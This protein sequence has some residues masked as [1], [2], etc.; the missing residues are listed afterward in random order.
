MRRAPEAARDYPSPA[1][2]EGGERRDSGNGCE[3]W[4]L[5]AWPVPDFKTVT[6]LMG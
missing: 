1:V 5:L 4:K 2:A 6:N 3:R